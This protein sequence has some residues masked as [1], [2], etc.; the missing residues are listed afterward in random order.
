M[1]E[2]LRSRGYAA[3]FAVGFGEAKKIIDN[4][5]KK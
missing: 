1:I 5:M 3:H 2:Q 4:Y